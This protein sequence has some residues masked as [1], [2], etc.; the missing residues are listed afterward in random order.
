MEFTARLPSGL[1]R[2]MTLFQLRRLKAAGE[3]ITAAGATDMQLIGNVPD[4]RLDDLVEAMSAHRGALHAKDRHV[5]LLAG[6]IEE[7]GSIEEAE[8][9][10]GGPFTV[11]GTT[12]ATWAFGG[13]AMDHIVQ[14]LYLTE[15]HLGMRNIVEETG[16]RG[17]EV[18]QGMK[19]LIAD[20][21]VRKFR[22][23]GG[24]TADEEFGLARNIRDRIDAVLARAASA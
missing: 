22:T 20:G 6:H 5:A 17:E 19:R 12:R 7:H 1:D 23:G 13:D 14:V 3:F 15:G 11:P 24:G 10:L 18:M 8:Q 16:R 21:V 4:D 9:H 2:A